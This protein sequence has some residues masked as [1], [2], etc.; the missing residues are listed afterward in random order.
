MH[1]SRKLIREDAFARA[2]K[3]CFGEQ[4]SLAKTEQARRLYAR[5]R[6]E[7]F[8]EQLRTTVRDQ[9]NEGGSS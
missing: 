6:T 2:I 7:D 4:T 3:E 5:Y 1:S 9:N 8:L